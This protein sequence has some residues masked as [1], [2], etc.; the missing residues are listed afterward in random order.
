MMAAFQEQVSKK[1][2]SQ[3]PYTGL[4]QSIRQRIELQRTPGWCREAQ[5]PS[6]SLLSW[7]AS[8]SILHRPGARC[9]FFAA[10]EREVNK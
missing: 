6:W 5:V 7:G 2:W 1:R 10:E 4:Q 8:R 3:Q 9:Y